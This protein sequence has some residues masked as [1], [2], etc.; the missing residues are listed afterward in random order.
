MSHAWNAPD[1]STW[2]AVG[3]GALAL[4]LASLLTPRRALTR[5]LLASFVGA[6][7]ASG[8]AGWLSAAWLPPLV[9]AAACGLPGAVRHVWLRALA[10]AGEPR[11]RGAVLLALGLVLVLSCGWLAGQG[12]EPLDDPVR[13]PELMFELRED[14]TAVARTDRGRRVPLYGAVLPEGAAAARLEDEVVQGW[15]PSLRLIRT[16]PPDW[17]ADCH[18]WTFTGGRWWVAGHD[19]EHILQDNG[20]RLVDAPRPGDVLVCRDE[21]GLPMHTGVV[22]AV[23]DDG[24]VLVESKWAWLGR[25]LHAPQDQPYGQ[26][27]TY[28]RSDRAGHHLVIRAAGESASPPADAVA[29]R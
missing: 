19:V 17:A 13:H 22:F 23:G 11:G 10:R 25:Y 26:R 21:V 9:L 8:A 5:A 15:G 16:G 20:Y 7:V 2:F 18:G 6:C 27:L 3:A 1:L 12:A 29:A 4:G 24:R 14:L 28:Y